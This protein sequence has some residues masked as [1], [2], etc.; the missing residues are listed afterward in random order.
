FR[1]VITSRMAANSLGVA[2]LLLIKVAVPAGHGQERA[3]AEVAAKRAAE[4]IRALQAESDALASQEKTLLVEL[5]QLELERQL[6]I[7]ELTQV[8][9]DTRALQATLTATAARADTLRKTVEAQRPDIDTRLAHLY[10]LG[11]A[12][13]WRLML[14]VDD[15]RTMGRAYR[16]ASALSHIDRERVEE[17]KRALTALAGERSALEARARDQKALQDKAARA[18][19]ALDKAVASRRLLVESIDARRDLNAQ[20]TGELQGAQQRLQ[21]SIGQLYTGGGEPVGL[22]L[23]P[24]R[25]AVPWPA[26]GGVARAFGRQPTARFGGSAVRNGIELSVAEGQP[27]RAVHE[28]IVAFA[29]Q[30]TG[31]GNLVIL[32]HGDKAFSLYGY[33]NSLRVGRGDRVDAQTEL[34]VSGRNPAGAPALYFELRVDGTAVDPLQRLKR[35]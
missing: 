15:L 20:L 26:R 32:E 10:K 12:G 2:L 28:G 7:E 16:T 21:A 27:V 23:R 29:D 5:R 9:R 19:A 22:P 13:Y 4:R 18:R 34:G 35:R 17:H 11:R 31:Y 25:G 3:P 30:F 24:F 1:E 8:E 33:L 14:D 6:K